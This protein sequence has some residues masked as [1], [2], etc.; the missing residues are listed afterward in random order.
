MK[1]NVKRITVEDIKNWC[2]AH[3]KQL[4][5]GGSVVT[6]SI[7]SIILFKKAK[8]YDAKLAQ[9]VSEAEEGLLRYLNECNAY[10]DKYPKILDGYANNSGES[11][12]WFV[13]DKVI[14]APVD[15]TDVNGDP[16]NAFLA[17][18]EVVKEIT[19][20][21]DLNDISCI[22]MMVDLK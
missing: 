12:M 6:A 22:E 7:I 5:I 4:I 9:D 3:K 18:N 16:D 1:D 10:R 2:A 8:A 11:T 17:I 15:F 20:N 19:S 21:I 14:N 13:A